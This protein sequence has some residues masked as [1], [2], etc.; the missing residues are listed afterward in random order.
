MAKRTLT[1][2][3]AAASRRRRA[4]H[5]EDAVRAL[6]ASEGWARWV[7]VRS[8]NGLSRYSWFNQVQIAAQRP[9]ASYVCGR[10]DWRRLGYDLADGQWRRPIWILAP[11][12]GKRPRRSP[13]R[14]ATRRDR[15]ALSLLPGGQGLRPLPGRPIDGAE[16]VDLAAPGDPLDRRLA[17]PP[18][19]V[20]SARWRVAGLPRDRPRARTRRRAGLVRS[21]AREIVVNSQRPANARVRILVHEIAHAH[22]AGKLDYQHFTRQQAEVLVD[23]VTYVVCGQVGLDVDGESVPYVA[24]WGEHGALQ[25]V[26]TFAET[27][28][29]VASA[30]EDAVARVDAR[31]TA[32][33]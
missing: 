4:R 32:A 17:R 28:D 15:A 23:T 5:L 26:H 9:D 29:A 1:A 8:R 11:F 27:V 14:P 16:P 30:I 25:A 2:E 18:A 7:R 22:P 33:G 24:S 13:T 20:R 6:L 31:P 12:T 3:Q 21:R 19:R 10:G